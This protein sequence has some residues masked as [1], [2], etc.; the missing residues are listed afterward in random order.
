MD[1]DDD[2]DDLDKILSNL[3][4]ENAGEKEEEDSADE[5]L[6]ILMEK[7]GDNNKPKYE[8]D[9][10]NLIMGDSDDDGSI[11][12]EE[13]QGLFLFVFISLLIVFLFKIIWNLRTNFN[14]RN[15]SKTILSYFL[16]CVFFLIALCYT[17]SYWNYYSKK[18]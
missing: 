10:P 6:D 9:E 15:S 5:L 14:W 16:V 11:D 13:E 8:Q 12:D 17:Y 1:F 18:I 4:S 7:Q 3:P 2:L